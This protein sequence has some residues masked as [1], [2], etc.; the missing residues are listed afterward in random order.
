MQAPV[1]RRKRPQTPRSSE[2]KAA[3]TQAARDKLEEKYAPT[4]MWLKAIY[5][6]GMQQKQWTSR[7]E[8]AKWL[9]EE[10]NLPS[11]ILTPLPAQQ[12]AVDTALFNR[13]LHDKIGK[14]E[15]EFLIKYRKKSEAC[16]P[17][18]PGADFTIFPKK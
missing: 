11:E 1:P 2:A 15:S 14:W 8:A 18:D 17:A 4:F 5:K 16:P 9:T 13:R 10:T 3:Q 12:D 7:A 6:S